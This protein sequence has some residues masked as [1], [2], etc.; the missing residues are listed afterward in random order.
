MVTGIALHNLH[1]ERLDDA[2]HTARLGPYADKRG[3]HLHALKSLE[4]LA[5][6]KAPLPMS[7]DVSRSQPPYYNEFSYTECLGMLLI[8]PQSSEMG[9]RMAAY[10]MS[11]P[12]P[13]DDFDAA[14]M[15]ASCDKYRLEGEAPDCEAVVFPPGSNIFELCVSPELLDRAMGENPD[16]RIKLHPLTNPAFMERLGIHY[17][18][19]RLI[20]QNISGWACLNKASTVYTTTASEMGLYAFLSGKHVINVTSYGYEAQGSYNLIYRLLWNRSPEDVVATLTHL[21]N[22]PYTGVFHPSDPNIEAKLELYFGKA[23]ELRE[24]FKPLV[25]EYSPREFA[26]I[27]NHQLRRKPQNAASPNQPK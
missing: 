22:S 8:Q 19:H 18:Y 5:H 9:A 23:M 7:F 11:A 10:A 3:S 6:A 20:D 21:L 24:T 13:F 15:V 2:S 27:V 12:L 25:R 14:S 26:Q 17:G 16:L 4:T 1:R